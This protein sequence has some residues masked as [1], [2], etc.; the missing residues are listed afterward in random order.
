M[1]LLDFDYDATPDRVPPI[2]AGVYEARIIDVPVLAEEQG[3]DGREVNTFTVKSQILP[4]YD[5]AANNRII[6]HKIW[7]DADPLSAGRVMVKHLCTSSGYIP[8]K[9][10]L[11]PEA[12]NQR[13][14]R[15]LITQRAGQN[16]ETGESELYSNVRDYLPPEA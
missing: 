5:E 4:Q 11:D 7:I 12:L 10:Q 15:L 13:V 2:P 6:T 1:T 3:K 9:G 8:A 16:K 14:V